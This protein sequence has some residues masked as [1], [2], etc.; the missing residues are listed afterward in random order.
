LN[1][2]LLVVKGDPLANLRNL[3]NV[4]LV[5]KDGKVIVDKD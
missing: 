2:N 1:A 4:L 3:E 5:M